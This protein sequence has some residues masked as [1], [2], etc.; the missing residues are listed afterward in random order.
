MILLTISCLAVLYSC[1]RQHGLAMQG[2]HGAD[3]EWEKWNKWQTAMLADPATGK[4]PE[5]IRAK[6]LAFAATLPKHS[7]P[8]T[9]SGSFW[10]N[11]GPW[12]VGGRTRAVAI[13]VTNENTILIGGACGGLWRSDNSGLT[14][15]KITGP[16]QDFSISCLVQDTR[17]GKTNTWYAGTGEFLGDN[18]GIEGD[19]ILKS[20]DGGQTF[21]KLAAT[22]HG[23]FKTDYPFA[24]V[25]NIAINEADTG[26]VI[27]AALGSGIANGN[28]YMSPDG[29]ATWVSIYKPGIFVTN[30][31]VAISKK[32]VIYFS[33]GTNGAKGGLFRT[34]DGKTITRITPAGFANSIERMV[35]GIDPN[36][37][38][39]VYFF[40]YTPGSGTLGA[41]LWKYSYISGNGAGKGGLWKNL[42]A[43][44]PN[45]GGYVGQ[46]N[47]QGGYNLVVKVKPGDSQTVFLG[48]TNLI[49]STDAFS[50]SKNVSW[51]G[52]YPINYTLATFEIDYPN[53]HPDQHGLVFYPSD[54]NK[55]LSTN[56]GGIFRTTDNRATP[57]VYSSLNNGYITTQ[58]YGIAIDHGTPGGNSLIGG[59]QDNGTYTTRSADPQT[60]WFHSFT[61]DGGYCAIVDGGQEYYLSC[62]L[63]WTFRVKLDST[64]YPYEYKRIDP[65]G[66]FNPWFLEPYI[67]D[68][69][70][71]KRMFFL[72]GAYIYR[73]DDLTQIP[74]QNVNINYD[75]LPVSTGWYPIPSTLDT[76]DTYTTLAMAH[77]PSQRL[78][79]GT[80]S[81]HLYKV[82]SAYASNPGKVDIT[83]KGIF[84]KGGFINCIAINPVNPDQMIVVFSNYNVKSLFTTSDG[85]T[86]WKDISANLEQFPNGTGNGPSCRW[87]SIMPVGHH[88]AYFIGTSTG[89]F[90]TDTL[91]GDSTVWTQ[92]SPD[93]IGNDIVSILDTRPSD[94]LLAVGT[95]GNG[96][97]TAN[98]S[99]AYQI[100]G[101]HNN[102]N[103]INSNAFQCYPNPV[104]HT[105]ILMVG[106]ESELPDKMM[107]LSIINEVG[108]IVQN[109][110]VIKSVSGKQTIPVS[111]EGLKPGIYYIRLE[112]DRNEVSKTFVVE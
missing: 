47:L 43:N 97:Y 91:M 52:G 19:G 59:M 68:P 76:I 69:N 48:F 86:T 104:A 20:T 82:D 67:L 81:A 25:N 11:R 72:D 74:L 65:A 107:A 95:Y 31:D 111:M 9:K 8:E 83:A 22:S 27:Y 53:H 41:S 32:G 24:Y 110:V 103:K 50:T 94:G 99:Y 39:T 54:P 105:N 78:V 13:D 30:S 62:Q 112:Q 79:F 70:D 17:P 42:S 96:I 55:M 77:S 64:G 57:I 100:S 4:I 61:G 109:P 85:G 29:G 80:Y 40:G 35:I 34:T 26:N 36:N 45:W 87:A 58:F 44:I 6:E 14:W 89:L 37:E 56:D 108:Q 28:V 73:N 12:N 33:V 46:P 101:I 84:P 93:G 38:N 10:Q 51:V 3:E 98:I 71:Q 18:G 23:A 63:G 106:I 88:F 15:K 49:R 2:R 1:S 21:S 102:F 16:A 66:A 92:Q 5:N 7:A 90:S 60:S 75:T